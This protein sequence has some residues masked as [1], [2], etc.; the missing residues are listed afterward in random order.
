[1]RGLFKKKEEKGVLEVR[2]SYQTAYH[3]SMTLSIKELKEEMPIIYEGKVLALPAGQY[4]LVLKGLMADPHR[5]STYHQVYRDVYGSF[6]RVQRVS[7]APNK[8]TVCTFEL[9][10]EVYEVNI[11]VVKGGQSI[12]GAEVLIQKADPNFHVTKLRQGTFFFL[13]PGPYS[14]VVSYSDYLVKD[15]IWVKE[16][17]TSFTIDLAK[18]GVAEARPVVAR[19]RD[20]RMV[21]GTFLAFSPVEGTTRVVRAE[22]GE[23]ETIDLE[24][25]KA[26]FF[27]KSYTG[28]PWYDEKKDFEIA[29]EFG[30]RAIV[31]FDDGEELWGYVLAAEVS[32]PSRRGFFLFPVDPESNNLKLYAIR[33]AV[34]EVRLS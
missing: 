30:R 31:R 34:A 17:H 23:E 14:V 7:V 26:L 3:H 15:V 33:S 6:E 28:R 4:T 20:G 11:H 8:T 2:L 13:E 24:A 27:V 12:D 32:D 5:E 21:K 16:D 10:G 29:R 22:D 25:L 1:M 19:F 18:E 9:P